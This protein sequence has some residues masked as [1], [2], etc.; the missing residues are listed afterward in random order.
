MIRIRQ[1]ATLLG[2]GE[3]QI[4][5]VFK[6]TLPTKLYWILFPIEDL[7]QAV[8]MAKRI[9][10]KEKLDKQ[11]TGQTSTSP[12]M[13]VRDGTDRRVSFN[14][15]EVLGDKIDKLTVIMSKLAAK[16]SHERKPF[17]PQIYKSRGQ[18]RGYGQEGYQTR[19]DNGNRGHITSNDS[20]LNYR[21]NNFRG[22]ARGYGRQNNREN[23][24]NERYSSNNR[25]RSR[26]R[27]RTLTR[28][29]FNNRDRS[30]SNNRSRSGSRSSTNRIE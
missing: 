7:R 3:P 30:P 4:L 12:F 5:E 26:T 15:R 24:R 8:E 28:N 21:S 19:S 23:Y 6:N 20:R 9:L 2:Y 11:L 25:G 1:V 16:D 27:E 22:T 10:T 17:K 13:S 29:Y 18:N 14:T